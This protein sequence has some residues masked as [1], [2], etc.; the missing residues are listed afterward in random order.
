MLTFSISSKT[1]FVILPVLKTR[2]FNPL[3]AAMAADLDGS[4]RPESVAIRSTT[5]SMP[6][7]DAALDFVQKVEAT[8]LG[9]V[10]KVANEVRDRM[11]VAGAAM[12]LKNRNRFGRSGNVARFIDHW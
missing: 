4:I 8:L 7:T 10:S 6:V 3:S 12:L 2:T 9:Q 1:R 11:L 5:L